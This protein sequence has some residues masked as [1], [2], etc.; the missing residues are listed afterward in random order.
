LDGLD[1]ATG[2]DGL[3]GATGDVG[4]AGPTGAD[5][6]IGATGHTGA[7]GA[8][9]ATG[10]TGPG[11]GA[12]G[13]TGATGA[14]GATGATGAAGATG[15][16]GAAGA[17]GATGAAGATGATGA[18]GA[19]GATGAAGATGAQSLVKTTQLALYADGNCPYGGIRIDTGI[20]TNGNGTLDAAEIVTAP[21]YLCK[22]AGSV[23]AAPACP[24]CAQ[25][26]A[27][28]T[29]T[30]Q[31][32]NVIYDA[33]ATFT[34][35]STS[36]ITAHVIV[37]GGSGANLQLGVQQ[38]GGSYTGCYGA[39]NPLTAITGT[40]AVDVTMSLATCNVALLS[41]A[42]GFVLS[43][44]WILL[45]VIGAGAAPV[46]PAVVLVDSI[47]ITNSGF[48]TQNFL[49]SATV[50]AAKYTANAAWINTSTAPNA[51]LTW[52]NK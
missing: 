41:D 22:D 50:S 48:T 30:G 27:S 15:A 12:T 29:A 28:F 2:A 42:T 32:V 51:T 4:A 49:T 34:V 45:Q 26:D 5:G 19:T 44:Q 6:L 17:T 33:P 3:K 20:D 46:N 25:I 23:A 35:N 11:G 40:G 47:S 10:A 8:A 9:G 52:Y 38:G 36:V 24:G 37:L 18:A 21:S 39:Y 7:T 13:A 43:P 1:G 14:D 31:S 16:T